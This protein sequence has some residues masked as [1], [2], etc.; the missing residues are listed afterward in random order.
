MIFIIGTD[1]DV[2]KTHY[3]KSLA[4]NGHYVIKPIETGKNTFDDLKES[5]CYGYANIL[6]KPISKINK[7]FFNTPASPHLAAELDN[8]IIDVH[9]VIQFIKDMKPDYVELAG[10]LMVPITREY[11]QLDLIKHFKTAKVDLVV[12]NKLGCINHAL[13]TL[14]LLKRESIQINKVIINTR[15]EQVISKDNETVI[16]NYYEHHMK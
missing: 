6:N 5:D 16:L 12:G 7:Y 11:S 10:G 14:E 8:T 13:L 4:E 9:E 3:G 15:D 2:G 1:T